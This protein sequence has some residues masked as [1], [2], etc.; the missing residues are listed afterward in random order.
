[1]PIRQ[2]VVRQPYVGEAVRA[3]APVSEDRVDEPETPREY[4]T[5]PTN[6]AVES[7]S[8][9]VDAQSATGTDSALYRMPV[10][11]YVVSNADV[12]HEEQVWLDRPADASR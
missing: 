5:S 4:R 8:S 2:E 3:P 1:M 12:L 7:R 11:A 10:D 6:G 9:I